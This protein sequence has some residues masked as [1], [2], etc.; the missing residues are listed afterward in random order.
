MRVRALY[1][2]KTVQG[3]V[4]YNIPAVL[5][6]ATGIKVRSS[7]QA[8]NLQLEMIKRSRRPFALLKSRSRWVSSFDSTHT[9]PTPVWQS[10]VK[11][12]DQAIKVQKWPRSNFDPG[13][14]CQYSRYICD[15]PLQRPGSSYCTNEPHPLALAHAHLAASLFIINDIM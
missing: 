4:T 1:I 2:L 3:V 6:P 15:H 14:G 5:T 13:R 11:R 12:C 8:A 10:R 7:D 9:P